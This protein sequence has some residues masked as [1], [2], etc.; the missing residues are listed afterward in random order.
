MAASRRPAWLTEP[1]FAAL[2]AYATLSVFAILFLDGFGPRDPHRYASHAVDLIDGGGVG[3]AD[4]WLLRWPMTGPLAAVFA[5]TGGS[6]RVAAW[7]CLMWVGVLVAVTLRGA[8]TVLGAGPGTLAAVFTAGSAFCA[9]QAFEVRIHGVET[10]FAAAA[11]WVGIA[12]LRDGR[13]RHLFWAGVLA[14]GA[15]LCRETAA[16]IPAVLGLASLV[17]VRPWRAAGRT[18]AALLRLSASSAGFLAVLGAEFAG[19]AAATGDPFFRLMRSANHEA[20]TRG[21]D[22][23]EVSGTAA[24]AISTPLFQDPVTDLLTMPNVT[25]FALGAV[26]LAGLAAWSRRGRLFP[27]EAWAGAVFG[28]LAVVSWAFSS[29]VLRLEE[30]LYAPMLPYAAGVFA[31]WGV[32]VLARRWGRAV[33]LVV[34]AWLVASAGAADLRDYDEWSEPRWLAERLRTGDLAEPVV[35]D[36]VTTKRTRDLLALT[37]D[38]ASLLRERAALCAGRL[39]LSGNPRGRVGGG[40]P[41]GEDWTLLDTVMTRRGGHARAVLARV[42][43]VRDV[44]PVRETL[45]PNLPVRLYR[46]GPSAGPCPD[47]AQG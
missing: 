8:R 22:P 29:Y 44:G 28:G 19:Y 41:P 37:G 47:D 9:A 16:P 31:G 30:V 13:A 39:V 40:V 32:A 35:S 33:L 4:H 2:L 20:V 21:A 14:G 23:R 42:P 36:N 11:C 27:G 26:L 24:D 46:A 3:P 6:E 10:A 45:G 43:V 25:P 38:D 15:W 17:A 18:R 34:P 12:G 5:V 1:R 7:V